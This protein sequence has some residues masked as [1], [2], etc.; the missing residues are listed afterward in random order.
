VDPTWLAALEWRGV[1]PF[2]GG[3]V[4]AVAGDPVH[5]HIF[6]FGSTGGG[7]WKTTDGGVYW[8]NVSDGAFKRASV[9]ALA[10]APSDPNVIYAGM[11]EATIRG[12]VSH[13]DGVWRST[14]GGASWSHL[15][16]EQARNIAKVR[17]H[18]QD[19]DV[20]YVA[21]LG[22]AHGPSEER[23]VFR[24]RDGGASW[25]KVL[26]VNEDVGVNELALDPRNPR[27]L[28]ATAWRAR[29]GPYHLES[30][31]PGCG[32]WR[33]TDGGDIW[34][35]LSRNKGLPTGTLGK[36]GVAVSPAREGRVYALVEHEQGGVFR[37]DDGGATWERRGDERELRERPWYYMHLVADPQDPETVWVLN[38]K[39][40][41]SHDGGKTFA[42]VPIPHGDNHD[43]WIDPAD[44]H[45]M[46]EG[47]DGGACVSFNG[48]ETWSSLYNQPTAEIYHVTA[49][50]LRPYRVYGAQ[51]DNSTI[52]LPSRSRY[53]AIVQADMYEVGGGESGYIAVR[54]DNPNIVY[55][56]SYQGYM[57]RYD[58]ATGQSRDITVR[59]EYMMGWPAREVRY[60]FQWTFPIVLSP[61]DPNV[62]Y[63]TGNVVFRSADEGASW[64][65][66]SPDLSRNDPATLGD[67]GGPL[68]RDNCGTEYYGTV[69]AFAESPRERGLLWAGTDDGLVHL[70][71]DDGG[72][73]QNVTPS[74]LPEWALISIIEPSPH[75]PAAAYLA[76]HRYKHD[77][78][79][80]YLFKTGDSGRTWTKIT[81]GIP[82]DEF[83]RVIREDPERRG[84]LY[85]GTEAGL[86]VS[87]DDGARWQSLR[88][89]LPVVPIHDLLVKNGDL[90][91]ATH[92]R[93][94]WILDDLSPLRQLF[95]LQG[96]LSGR[97]LHLFAPRPTM[98]FTT[99]GGFGGPAVPGRNY[100][101]TSA[102][103]VAY[104]QHEKPSGEKQDVFLDAGQNP[105]E[106]VVVSYYLKEKPESEIALTFLDA[107]G[108]EIRRFTSKKPEAEPKTAVTHTADDE[109]DATGREA[110]DEP[111]PLAK[112]P[113]EKQ[114]PRVPKEAGANRFVW[115]GRNPDPTTIEGAAAEESL[116][117]SGAP[118]LPGRYTVRLTVG[119]RTL[120][121]P[122]ELLADPNVPATPEELRARFELLRGIGAAVARANEAVNTIRELR[123]QA[124]DWVRRAQGTEGVERLTAAG[125]VLRDALTPI[126]QA[127]TEPKSQDRLDTLDYPIRASAKLAYLAALAGSA[128]AAPTKQQCE[129]FEELRGAVEAQ[130]AQLGRVLTGEVAAFNALVRELGVAPVAPVAKPKR[131]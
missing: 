82:A 88:A 84:L 45:R 123:R 56:G 99:Y 119:D 111:Y 20:V 94:I 73:W 6:Y 62:L 110:A 80:P 58:H 67:S 95:D 118:A 114:E 28:Y 76:A 24:S 100:R 47:N 89:N 1:G 117:L 57:T 71:R 35:E 121:Q 29:R 90:V 52:S 3:R 79:T 128:D 31:G 30:G 49:D 112:K 22:H 23:G 86:Y 116:A 78:F 59:P 131:D 32:L 26:Y 4:A 97:D 87:F 48:A 46:I 101:S 40:F 106:G 70:S 33:S 18:P 81:D 12:N 43:L 37:S 69:F 44:P 91:A 13:G 83:T 85:A 75:D 108:N 68:T 14:D 122:F 109:G 8:E 2:R 55:A 130:V 27:I 124:D 115:N 50:T 10:V 17:V 96:E 54:P 25:E 113:E 103:I 15:G 11:G 61:H 63:A 74:E 16:L 9:G 53:G 127:L 77:E 36:L 41:R 34:T 66:I 93:G 98:R 120:E 64:E 65:A 42:H 129:V 39:L 105:T 104:R 107:A 72:A 92:G 38:V 125:K 5:K 51:Q 19:A 60:R 21:A 126:E 102:F 7:V